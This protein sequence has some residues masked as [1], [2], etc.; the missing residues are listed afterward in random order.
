MRSSNLASPV[1]IPRI[2]HYCWFGGKPLP[3]S[4]KKCIDSWKKYFPDYEIKQWNEN[5]FDVNFNQYTAEAY[6][7]GK[8]AFLSD[9]A[10]LFVVEKYGGIYFDV[11][12][13]VVA[14]YDDILEKGAFF[15][16]ENSGVLATGLGFGAERGN[17]LIK[18]MLKDYDNRHFLKNGKEDLTPC[19]VLNSEIAKVKGFSLDNTVETID[20]VTIYPQ[21][22]FNPKDTYSRKV[23]STENTHSI[24]H[25]DGSWLSKQE[26]KRATL[27]AK[28]F[29]L[30]G[31]R[32]GGAIYKSVF[33]PYILASHI[34]QKKGG[35]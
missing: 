6:K 19:P 3:E 8:Y 7:R 15:G 14:K 2:I 26:I 12:V 4:A 28:L 17:W 21:E 31:E 35:N 25:Y 9:V 27:R 30:F 10:R 32:M 29:N 33:S 13:E 22:Y 34:A 24:H 18:A 1:G 5:N 23:M 11:D 20:G 16:L